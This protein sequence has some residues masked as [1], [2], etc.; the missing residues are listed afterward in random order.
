M[1]KKYYLQFT[2]AI[3]FTLAETLIVMGIIGVVAALTLPNLNSST[4]NKEKVAKVKKIYQNLNDA[5][6]RATAVY[7]P[8]EEW[9]NNMENPTTLDL[10]RKTAERFSDFLKI[11]KICDGANVQG[12]VTDEFQKQLDGTT[13]GKP[14][15]LA[16]YKTLLADGTS[17]QWWIDRADC[18]PYFPKSACPVDPK[19]HVCGHVTVDIDGPNKGPYTYGKDLF[20]FN[21]TMDGIYPI[22]LEEERKYCGYVEGCCFK[23]GIYCTGWI[24][25]SDNMDYLQAD[26][27]GKCKN[28]DKTLSWTV[29]S[30][31]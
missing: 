6:G 24:M 16:I 3:A 29:L 17:I 27:T 11:T 18:N 25:K 31:N 13:N 20:Q 12:C 9:F 19:E 30:C 22:L 7:G 23:L 10:G 26:R 1:L 4:G 15:A 8:I 5:F 21:V 28:S 14:S 2:K